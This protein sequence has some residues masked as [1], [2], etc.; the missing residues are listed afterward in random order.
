MVSIMCSIA[1]TIPIAAC[2]MV[3]TKPVS[4]KH[5][6]FETQRFLAS[7]LDHE[8]DLAYFEDDLIVLIPGFFTKPIGRSQLGM[9]V[10]CFLIV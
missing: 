7:R 5:L 1:L 2:F 10:L 3:A 8:Y 6:G 4:P 9:I